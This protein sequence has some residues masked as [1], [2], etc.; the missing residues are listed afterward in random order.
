MSLRVLISGAGSIAK[1]HAT[2]LFS[3]RPDASVMA[4]TRQPLVR[5]ADWPTGVTAAGS[6]EDGM[7]TGADAVMICGASADH[8]RELLECIRLGL[9][10]FV[11]KPLLTHEGDLAK[12]SAALGQAH[13][14]SVIG[15][16]L[17]FLRS[18]AQLRAALAD[19]VAGR[20]VRVHLEVGQ[21][22][23]D[24]R[25]GRPLDS[26]YSADVAAGGG[27]V[28]DLV[29]EIDAALWLL[30]S[31]SLLNVAGGQLSSLP[32]KA[33][34][35]A[36]AL[37]RDERGC[38]V[39]ISLDYVSRRP[40]RRYVFVGDQGTLLWDLQQRQLRLSTTEGARDLTVDPGDFAVADTY[41][42][43]LAE[44]LAAIDAHTPP[45]TCPLASSL[46]AASLMLQIARRLT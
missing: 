27:V 46:A 36:V 5:L 35:T 10:V 14:A 32:L 23:P 16:N 9:P 6:F 39:T 15:C 13:P 45:P 21:W 18:L 8:A 3:V 37:L 31:L 42:A 19:G 33:P 43:E 17:R 38:P 7:E 24:W 1:R 12:V 40:V 22:L 4:V 28:F 20:L 44:W 26:C 25:P 2:N 41:P 30:G 29:H 34:D 11:E